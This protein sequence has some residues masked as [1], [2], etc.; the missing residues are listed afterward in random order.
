MSIHH[1]PQCGII[2][3]Q[4]WS[5][6]PHCQAVLVHEQ[7][8]TTQTWLRFPGENTLSYQVDLSR[9]TPS[10]TFLKLLRIW[11]LSLF[12]VSFFPRQFFA[13]HHFRIL[14]PYALACGLLADWLG[15]AFALGTDAVATQLTQTFGL[16]SHLTRVRPSILSV[17][18]DLPLDVGSQWMKI[19][20]HLNQMKLV[21]WLALR[22]FISLLQ[23]LPLLISLYFVVLLRLKQPQP[24]LFRKHILPI[25]GFSL[26]PCAFYTFTRDFTPLWILGILFIGL[27]TR[28]AASNWNIVVTLFITMVG[29]IIFFSG[30]AAVGLIGFLFW[31][32]LPAHQ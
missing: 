7:D 20:Q 13:S 23:M 26:F 5:Q 1:C 21:A 30:S 17:L 11:I 4:D 12:H 16:W 8:S 27:R 25:V 18:D 29:S 9:L 31:I 2:V 24:G 15:T 14:A 19:L 3:R 28:L 10:E 22:P 32:L 6:C